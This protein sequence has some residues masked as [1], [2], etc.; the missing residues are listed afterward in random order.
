MLTPL[1]SRR[2]AK[3]IGLN[4]LDSMTKGQCMK[5]VCLLI[6]FSIML[7]RFCLFSVVTFSLTSSFIWYL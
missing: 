5:L 1:I 3:K 2:S 6:R 4:N 7:Q